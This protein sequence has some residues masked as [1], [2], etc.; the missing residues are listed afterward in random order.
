MEKIRSIIKKIIPKKLFTM[1]QPIYH[2]SLAFFGAMMYG[3]PSRRIKIVAVT[4]TKGKTST[5]E[6]VNA[7]L[8]EAGKKTALAGTLRFKIGNESRPNVYK[9]TMPGRFF[10]QKFLHDAVKADCE[11]AVI[12]ISSE[13]ARQY[14]HKFIDLNALIFTNLAPEHIESHGSY[15][16]YVAAK[17][18]IADALAHSKKKN[19]VL[20]VN[21][22]DAE[23]QKFL[24]VHVENKIEY[25]ISDAEQISLS[26]KNIEFMYKGVRINSAL[27][28]KFNIYNMLGAIKYAESQGIHVQTIARGIAQLKNIQGRAERIDLGQDFR[29]IVDYAHT[30]ESLTAIYETFLGSKKIG[31]LGSCGGGRDKWKR[32]AMAEIA[33]RYCEEIILTDEDPYDDDPREIVDDL[34][35]YFTKHTPEIIMDRR[36]AIASAIARAHTDDAIIITGKGTDPYIMRA[37]GVKE[38]WSDAEVAR[39]ELKKV[40]DEEK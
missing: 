25:G 15:E 30:P 1:A 16:N 17:L 35:Q 39:E 28:G 27:L 24:A 21:R 2:Y 31:V 29:V 34:A 10:I 22:D 9:M 5:V 32:K 18:S 38:K 7:I 40:I 20:V 33:D 36:M 6:F 13:A 3:F 11:Y 4:G 19:K 26:E 8:E 14:R 23:A 37:S 12:E